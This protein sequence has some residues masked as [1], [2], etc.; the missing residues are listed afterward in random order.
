MGWHALSAGGLAVQWGV[1][2]WSIVIGLGLLVCWIIFRLLAGRPKAAADPMRVRIR[3]APPA[4]QS[5]PSTGMQ[6]APPA[7]QDPHPAN[8]L[9]TY[10][11]ATEFAGLP[12][13]DFDPSEGVKD[14]GRVAYRLRIDWD[15]QEDGVR[16]ADKLSAFLADPGAV[17]T[18]ALVIGN[19]GEVHAG[20]EASPIVEALAAAA[21][22]LPNLTAL[23]IGDIVMEESEI[24]WI[25][26][27]DL[28]P[29]VQA[30]PNLERLRV[31]GGNNLSLGRMR[32]GRLRSLIIETGGLPASVVHEVAEAE[33]PE[34]EHL[35]LWLGTE[36]YGWDGSIDDVLP[37]LAAG[38]FPKLRYL[39]LRDS[40]ISDEIAMAL[41]SSS[42]LEQLEVLDL[43]LG[44][45]SDEG[46]AALAASPGVAKLKRLDIHHNYVSD[47]QVA[48]LRKLDIE[49]DA[50][51]P[52]EA[53]DDGGEPHRYVAV[54]E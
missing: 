6:T 33:L 27:S 3:T 52:Q 5:V 34:L 31:R 40:E 17:A 45:L 19:W 44:T 46:A 39:G 2:A 12:V 50:S 41:A 29:L 4:D 11:N 1:G 36:D 26:Q 15:E 37:L 35:E 18:T 51:D 38:R 9:P 25:Q 20:E 48:A 13:V 30:Y 14:P 43:S 7:D 49:F 28:S 24:S 54:S 23:F 32:L 8:N 42:I 47:E 21:G 53:D 16:V 10:E 22:K